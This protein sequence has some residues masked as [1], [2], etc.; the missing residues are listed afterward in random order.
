MLKVGDH[1]FD[2]LAYNVSLKGAKL[3]ID[4]PLKTGADVVVE[5]RNE[6]TINAKIAWQDDGFLGLAFEPE[7]TE[8]KKL[9]GDLAERL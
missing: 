5:I 2:C 1:S 6:W 9:L 8:I 4:L 3:K 7:D